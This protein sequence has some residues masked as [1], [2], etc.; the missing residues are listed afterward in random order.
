MKEA[1]VA[2]YRLWPL[3]RR[4]D[5]AK[6]QQFAH[7]VMPRTAMSALLKAIVAQSYLYP[8][9]NEALAQRFGVVGGLN[10]RLL[11]CNYPLLGVD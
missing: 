10:N 4:Y 6:G 5:W 3:R 7:Y 9:Y 8:V 2:R 11:S 1:A